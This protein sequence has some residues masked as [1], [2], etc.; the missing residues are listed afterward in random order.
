M[1]SIMPAIPPSA[2]PVQATLSPPPPPPH[3]HPAGRGLMMALGL[4]LLFAGVETGAGIWA[5]SLVLLSDAGHM[6]SDTLALGLSLLAAW[7]ARRP[8]S[9]R[10]SYGYMR[11][12]ILVA[13]VNSLVLLAVVIAIIVAAIERLRHPQPVAGLAVMVVAVIGIAVNIA[14]VAAL[15]REAHSL[16]TRSAILH[17]L[18]DLLGSA[19]ALIAG[20][21]IYFTGWM[22]IDS[23]LSMVI[24]TLI[25]YSTVRLLREVVNILMEG[26]PVHLD[27][28]VVGRRMAEVA[29]VLSVHD[30]HIWTLSSGSPALSAHIVIDDQADWRGLLPTLQSIL[31]TEFAIS[32]V[33]LQPEILHSPARGRHAVIPIHQRP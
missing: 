22:P 28:R 32:H 6:F 30:L 20:A 33:T 15:S 10:H 26:V 9:A 31:Q 16:N 14:V 3:H 24:A 18:G 17:V 21:V 25:L 19:T 11:S 23:I 8:P 2:R 13:L 29:A 12:E 1:P 4:T 27:L 7:L 5:H